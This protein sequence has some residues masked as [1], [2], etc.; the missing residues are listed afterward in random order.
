MAKPYMYRLFIWFCTCCLI[1]CTATKAIAQSAFPQDTIGEIPT[2]LQGK[3]V[4][5]VLGGGGALGYAHIGALQALE[6]VGIRPT[7]IA[8]TS[9]GALIGV[10]YAEGYTSKQLLQ[11]VR[12]YRLYSTTR[13]MR[14]ASK[15]WKRGIGSFEPVRTML[16]DKL[17]HDSFDSLSIPFICTATNL[18]T[19]Q[20]AVHSTG[21]H[22]IDWVLASASIPIVF[23]PQ[24]IDS[25]Y[26][27]DGGLIDNLPVAHVPESLYDI[28]IAIDLVP[29]E[30]MKT[31]LF[32]TKKYSALN[33]YGNFLL[34]H[35]S[36]LGR[37]LCD[38]LIRPN[39][40]PQYGI[41]DFEQ[42][43]HFYQQGYQAMRIW[44]QSIAPNP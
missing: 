34:A 38:Y 3:R 30:E 6:E 23:Q 43:E 5:V 32:F 33:V 42:Y 25:V 27:A 4:A 44:L 17:P 24:M 20:L 2:T 41:M 26:F 13:I 35:N 37:S 39:Q 29:T 28:V 11:I 40:S 9:M 15:H 22:L 19:Q 18:S 14:P 36:Q 10:L 21:N 16:R 8:G 31:E 7:C 1:G 12:D